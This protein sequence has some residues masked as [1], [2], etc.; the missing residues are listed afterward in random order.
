MLLW[1]ALLCLVSANLVVSRFSP[2]E[3]F[4]GYDP[5]TI[6][7]PFNNGLKS[8]GSS[9]NVRVIRA[10]LA[11]RQAECPPDYTGC[12]NGITLVPQFF[13]SPSRHIPHAPLSWSCVCRFATLSV[14][15]G[16][17]SILE[18]FHTVA[19]R[20]VAFVVH[21]L[22]SRP[23]IH[24][25]L[26]V[27]DLYAKRIGCCP[28]GYYCYSTGCCQTGYTGCAGN[29]CCSPTESCCIGGGCC[30]EGYVSNLPTLG[31]FS[32]S[33][34]C[35]FYCSVVEGVR[36]CCQNGQTCTQNTAP[37]ECTNPGY[38]LCPGENFCCRTSTLTTL[39]RPVLLNFFY[40]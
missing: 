19:V 10:L 9:E 29:S 33:A 16:V 34:W 38:V 5:R 6:L 12:P 8:G 22:V 23:A 21:R 27:P 11:V 14:F 40:L 20:P 30:G 18:S 24:S 32:D 39:N 17:C 25:A 26:F 36:G 3:V 37:P 7:K 4:A 15:D 13:F 35:R 31:W 1:T 2:P 28:G